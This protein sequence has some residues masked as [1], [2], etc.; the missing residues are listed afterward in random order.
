MEIHLD[1]K[2]AEK[3]IFLLLTLTAQVREEK[4]SS[5]NLMNYKNVDTKKLLH[6]MDEIAGIELLLER[7]KATKNN[8]EFFDDE[9]LEDPIPNSV[10]PGG[11]TSFLPA[12][13]CKCR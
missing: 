2:I 11:Q 3:R 4:R 8:G 13:K 9:A 1:R 5:P 12:R 7:L 10:L 6:P